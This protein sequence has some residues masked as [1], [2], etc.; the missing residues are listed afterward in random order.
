[1]PGIVIGLIAVAPNIAV[2]RELTG[3]A[4]LSRAEPRAEY[5]AP[6][7]S[8]KKPI[9][10]G[11]IMRNLDDEPSANAVCTSHQLNGNASCLISCRLGEVSLKR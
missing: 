8:L 10:A 1:M 2:I 7:F 9:W 3:A 6:S 11:S 4:P 5:I